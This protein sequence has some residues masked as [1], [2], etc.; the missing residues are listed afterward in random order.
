[1]RKFIANA[2]LLF[3]LLYFEEKQEFKQLKYQNRLS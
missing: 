3:I 1:M 2:L